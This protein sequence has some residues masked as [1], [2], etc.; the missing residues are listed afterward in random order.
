MLIR[1]NKFLSQAGAAS[2]RE[3]DRLI[4]QGR[5]QVN[6]RIVQEL[7][8]KIEDETDKVDL[9]G[10]RVRKEERLAYVLLHKPVGTVVT[11]RDP[12]GRKT[13]QDLLRGVGVRVFPVGRLDADSSG[14]LLLTNDGDLAFHLAHPRFEVGKVYSVKVEGSPEETDLAK[15]RK[16]IFLEGRKTAPAKVTMVSRSAARGVVRVEIH[17]GRKREV[18][19]MFE[20]LGYRVSDLKRTSFAGLTLE[21]LKPGQWRFLEPGE[22]RMLKKKAGLP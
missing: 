12:F 1:L 2:R 17:E 8:E 21:R 7:G 3:A 10:K 18:R 19:K 6:G 13:V 22:I 20:A 9:D 5:V 4:E 15:L 16:G 11:L 14:V